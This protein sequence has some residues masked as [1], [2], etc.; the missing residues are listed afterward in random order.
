MLGEH[1]HI[2]EIGEGRVIGDERQKPPG[3][4]TAV[5]PEAE[6]VRSA[7]SSTS[8]GIP[9][10]NTRHRGIHRGVEVETRAIGRHVYS[11]CRHSS[12]PGG[13]S[14]RA[15]ARSRAMRG[16]RER[17]V[18]IP[19]SI[20]S[21][22]TTAAPGSSRTHAE[23]A[24][25]RRRSLVLHGQVDRMLVDQQQDEMLGGRTASAI[26]CALPAG[27]AVDERLCAC[28]ERSVAAT[29]ERRAPR[30]PVGDVQDHDVLY[31]WIGRRRVR[32]RSPA[33][34][35]TRSVRGEPRFGEPR[36][37]QQ[38][39]GLRLTAVQSSHDNREVDES[40]DTGGRMIDADTRERT[41][42]RQRCP[43]RQRRA[44]CAI[45]WRFG[46]PLRRRASARSSRSRT[47]SR[48]STFP[49]G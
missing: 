25:R 41:G 1:E 35:R 18:A 10:T 12:I 37:T 17:A 36:T 45:G 22:A 24:P 33:F 42:E 16:G 4:R 26:A 6:R 38:R 49:A 28:D 3:R 34:R 23:M 43:W 44:G 32:R 48:P 40:R 27:R 39:P 47:V 2:T 15:A 20:G 21:A 7:I 19:G 11:M 8:R 5:Q 14:P 46:N 13:L 29:R 30:I 31:T 9:V